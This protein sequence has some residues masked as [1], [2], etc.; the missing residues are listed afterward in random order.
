MSYTLKYKIQNVRV[1]QHNLSKISPFAAEWICS[2]ASLFLPHISFL[3]IWPLRKP[4]Q[5]RRIELMYYC[6]ACRFAWLIV[7]PAERPN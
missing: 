4:L 5:N 3:E 2:F 6:S 1:Q 7:Q